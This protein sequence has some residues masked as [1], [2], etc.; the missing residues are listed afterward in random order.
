MSGHSTQSPTIGTTAGVL[1]ESSVPLT[2]CLSRASAESMK[3]QT[4]ITAK[5]SNSVPSDTDTVPASKV[6]SNVAIL[7]SQRLRLLGKAA[8]NGQAVVSRFPKSGKGI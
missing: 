4:S 3:K 1:G 7:L 2:Q 8:P 6:P 5:D